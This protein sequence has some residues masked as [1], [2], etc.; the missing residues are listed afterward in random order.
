MLKKIQ[1]RLFKKLI[2][3]Q[4]LF[5]CFQF[6]TEASNEVTMLIEKFY[7]KQYLKEINCARAKSCPLHKIY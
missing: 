5:Q 1:H 3:V 2:V 4:P 6:S 7:N